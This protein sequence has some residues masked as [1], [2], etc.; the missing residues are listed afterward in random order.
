M[1]LLVTANLWLFWFLVLYTAVE[2]LVNMSCK[3]C[4][5]LEKC[6]LTMKLI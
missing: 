6:I 1:Y 4:V 3:K 2:R 5:I